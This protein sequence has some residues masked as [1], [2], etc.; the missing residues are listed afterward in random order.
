MNVLA[1]DIGSSSARVMLCDE[2]L[3]IKEL[4][5]Y[6]HTAQL[7]N[8]KY[9]WDII[10]LFNSL[11]RAID[12]A[13]EKYD[14]CS[15]GICSWGVDYG[16]IDKKGN[17]IDNPYCYRDEKNQ[18]EYEILH[19]KISTFKLFEKSAI[20]PNAIN[21]MYQLLSD[22]REK[23][24]NSNEV[25]IAM[26]ADLF[27]Y[28]LTGNIAIE[29]SNASTTGLLSLDGKSWNIS[30]IR[31]LGI[32]E[33]I[34][35][36]LINSGDSYGF[37][38]NIV[39]RAV[40]THDTASAIYA[41]G[42]LDKG[43]SFLSSGSWLLIGKLL[44]TPIV[45]RKVY[46]IMCTNER[47]ND[48]KVSLLCN[49]NGL[50]IIQRVVSEANLSYKDIDNCMDKAKVLGELDVDKL[51]SP[52]NMIGNIKTMLGIEN[53]DI[54]DICKTIY[55]S[56]AKRIQKVIE[57]LD[58]ITLEKTKRI[59]LT[60]GA[61]RAKYFVSEVERLVGVEVVLLSGE[62]AVLGNAKRQFDSLKK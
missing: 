48:N 32:D 31:E 57:E 12:D 1:I 16:V 35:P 21:T 13:I 20:Y 59:I 47:V 22:I 43:D 56:L 61:S 30:L 18:I 7:E 14:I 38:K 17:I 9:R 44:D 60:G 37:Y 40:G 55:Y 45:N 10:A 23:R 4:F 41:M 53:C 62:G 19:K 25:K 51:M 15:I 52:N 58:N 28:Y 2:N 36:N 24:Y 5:R 6:S 50:F 46:D 33:N 11:K 54:M 27:A 39:V 8:G 3:N 34:F 29:C 42:K 26:I 49:I